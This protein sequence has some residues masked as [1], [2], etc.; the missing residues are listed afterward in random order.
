MSSY[1]PPPPFGSTAVAQAA[2][3]Q[4]MASGSASFVI[5]LLRRKNTV[6]MFSGSAAPMRPAE[7]ST[8]CR[9]KKVTY[10]GS[11]YATIQVLGADNPDFTLHGKLSAQE[12]ERGTATITSTAMRSH[13]KV[14]E[15]RSELTLMAM[16]GSPLLVQWSLTGFNYNP[17]SKSFSMFPQM[18]PGGSSQQPSVATQPTS[19][20][21]VYCVLKTI[22]WRDLFGGEYEYDATF[23]IGSRDLEWISRRPKTGIKKPSAGQVLQNLVDTWATLQQY[24]SACQEIYST[25]VTGLLAKITNAIN[26]VSGMIQSL[27]SLASLP[28]KLARQ[29]LAVCGAVRQAIKDCVA[30][31]LDVAA[32]YQAIKSD[33]KALEGNWGAKALLSP[34]CVSVTQ[35]WPSTADGLLW[36]RGCQMEQQ[37]FTRQLMWGLA[38]AEAQAREVLL[39]QQT[40]LDVYT[41]IAGD[42]LRR[43]ATKFYHDPTQWT[44]IATYNNLTGDGSI[45]A[46]DILLVPNLGVV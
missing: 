11:D 4:S 19:T 6:F 30:A 46:G 12:L 39:G 9:T 41:V 15:M 38:Q 10:P 18:I 43:V 17:T 28:A 24:I 7:W 1:I 31:G 16:L 27:I 8:G 25:Y 37:R 33:A 5:Q 44:Q 3:Q 29:A 40:I 2:A 34:A 20:V 23:E 35:T 36:A 42:T 32:Q 22:N 21:S 13:P 45:K 14:E 26:A